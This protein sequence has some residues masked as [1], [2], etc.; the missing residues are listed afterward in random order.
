MIFAL[1][2]RFTMMLAVFTSAWTIPSRW[3]AASAARHSRTIAI[4]TPGLSRDCC[5]PAVTTTL[6]MYRQR[7]SVTLAFVR[8]RS[9]G[10]TSRE[11]S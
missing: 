7:S 8:S 11:R 4:A 5:G 10:A 9:S 3:S 2:V 6:L 1:P